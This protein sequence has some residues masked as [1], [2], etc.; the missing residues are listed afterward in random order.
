MSTFFA[1]CLEIILV[2]SQQQQ[3][4]SPQET[5][6]ASHEQ[7]SGNQPHETLAN[8][9]VV[10]ELQPRPTSTP[11]VANIQYSNEKKP[12][13]YGSQATASSLGTSPPAKVASSITPQISSVPVS[14]HDQYKGWC[15][16]L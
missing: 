15:T 9:A 11:S 4:Q 8:G 14:T 16:L 13:S 5:Q 10:V 3:Q 7:L 6:K 2:P 12:L 1:C